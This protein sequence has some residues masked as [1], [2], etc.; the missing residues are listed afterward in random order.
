MLRHRD[1]RVRCEEVPRTMGNPTG[2]VLIVDD[3]RDCSGSIR[4][5]LKR[6]GS[7]MT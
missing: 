5:V 7:R 1:L 3:G 4:A 2:A 6:N